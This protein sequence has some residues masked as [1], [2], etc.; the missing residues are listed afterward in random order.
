M[1]LLFGFGTIHWYIA[2]V[3]SAWYFAH[4]TSFLFLTLAIYETFTKRRPFLIGLLLGASYWSRLPTILS[5]PFF[6]IMLSDNE[7]LKKSNNPSS[8]RINFIPLLKLGL[9]VGIFVIL[10]FAYNYLRFGTPFDIAYSIQAKAE[11]WLYPKGL[12]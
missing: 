4:I 11:P 8:L 2:S 10:N 6:L 1:T 12:F 9:G 3:G 7:W 5:L